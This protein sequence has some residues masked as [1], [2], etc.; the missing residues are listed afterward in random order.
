MSGGNYR[1]WWAKRWPR[2]LEPL[3]LS[4]PDNRIVRARTL[5]RGGALDDLIVEPGELT[6]W[7]DL[8]GRTFGVTV[9]VAVLDEPQW[10][11][12]EQA[13]AG[14]V[15]C[16]ADLLDDRLPEDVDRL[17][18]PVGLALFPRDGELTTEC[19]C[20][21]KSPVCVHVIAVQHGFAARFDDDPFLLPLLRGRERR[22]LLAGV[23]SAMSA[24]EFPAPA[25][26]LGVAVAS[27]PPDGFYAV[28][29]ARETL[30]AWGR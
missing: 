2:T 1:T 8:P 16:L 4:Y 23:R 9:R 7:V 5:L 3:G 27:L 26:P 25:P 10:T 11:L 30:A 22:A 19:P 14:R 28:E 6:A 24:S 15:S 20:P 12:A 13:L 21:S 18:D 17:L 29:G